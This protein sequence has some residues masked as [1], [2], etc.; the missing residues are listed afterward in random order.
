MKLMKPDA[1]TES[2]FVLNSR[3][4]ACP[5]RKADRLNTL[6]DPK[7]NRYNVNGA[8]SH[9][10]IGRWFW[11]CKNPVILMF[12]RCQ[13]L[14]TVFVLYAKEHNTKTIAFYLYNRI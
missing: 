10:H 13:K 4:L 6:L 1:Q 9:T 12:N 2:F 3:E 11:A 5:V 7:Q 14:A 8:R